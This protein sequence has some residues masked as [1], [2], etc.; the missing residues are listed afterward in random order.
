M[1]LKIPFTSKA[2]ATGLALERLL[3]QIERNFANDHLDLN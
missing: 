3:L 1:L 2:L